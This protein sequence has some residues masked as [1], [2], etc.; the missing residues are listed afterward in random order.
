MVRESSRMKNSEKASPHKGMAREL[1]IYIHIPF[2]VRKCRYCD[3]LSMPAGEE[4]IDR[5][6]KALCNEIRGFA[7]ADRYQ[8]VSVFLGGGTPSILKGEQIAAI[9]EAVRDRFGRLGP[10]VE[11]TMEC[12]PGTLDKEK[13][14]RMREAG[15]NRLS[16]GLQSAD[17]AELKLLGRIHTWE[18]FCENYAAAREAGFSNINIDLMSA[19]PGQ[20]VESWKRTLEQVLALRPEHISA[21]SLIIEE[22]TP[23]YDQYHK[24]DELRQDG[25]VLPGRQLPTE[26]EERLMYEETA[27]ILSEAGMERYEISNYAMP[28]YE[29]IH[30]CGYWE[31][32][33]YI[34]FGLGASSC[35]E[36]VRFANTSDLGKYLETGWKANGNASVEGDANARPEADVNARLETDADS[37]LKTRISQESTA[38]ADREDR[39]ILT[40]EDIISETMFLGLRMTKGVD[41]E[42]FASRFGVRAEEL[43]EEPIRKYE[44][45]GLLEIRDGRLR[46]TQAGMFVS[47]PIMAQFLLEEA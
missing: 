4:M 1:G 5:Y 28:G 31:R 18:M 13:L 27:F 25:K 37:D 41:L 12:N 3:F 45:M 6:V 14:G 24:E 17:N 21:Y 22:G 32:R 38:G 42:A 7:Y 47:N 8:P 46:L 2:C 33:E 29:S 30:N 20:T 34:G 19:L 36:D 15:I 40:R 9:L 10:E 43:F 44:R 11:I 39:T 35:L 23:F 26:E 16:I